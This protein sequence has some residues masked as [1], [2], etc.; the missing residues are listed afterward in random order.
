MF[1]KNQYKELRGDLQRL[2]QAVAHS[3]VETCK[4]RD[5][6][7]AVHEAISGYMHKLLDRVVEL[8][9]VRDGFPRDAVAHRG[10]AARGEKSLWEDDE[11]PEET[12]P[13]ESGTVV[14]MRG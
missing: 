14:N 2:A 6:V 9:M 11:E 4:T 1:N 10:Q 3:A 13:P 7:R 5:E 8:V 12:W